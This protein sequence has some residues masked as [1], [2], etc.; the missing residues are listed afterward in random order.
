MGLKIN[1]IEKNENGDFYVTLKYP[2][3]VPI[4]KYCSVPST[5]KKLYIEFNSRFA[6]LREN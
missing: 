6:N 5:R 1:F 2:V 4:M 3:Y